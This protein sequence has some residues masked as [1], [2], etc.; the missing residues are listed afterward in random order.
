M[1]RELE[2]HHHTE[3]KINIEI[4]DMYYYS[5]S[6]IDKFIKKVLVMDMPMGGY[7]DYVN[8]YRK[9]YVNSE[10]DFSLDRG[11]WTVSNGEIK[12]STSMHAFVCLCLL[13][14]DVMRPAPLS[15]CLCDFST[16]DCSLEL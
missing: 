14:A 9:N 13:T 16:V 10:W 3:K 11:P 12:V 7:L 15:S 2:F 1:N 4:T 5:N 6:F 8:S